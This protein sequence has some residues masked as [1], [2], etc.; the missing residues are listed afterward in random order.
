MA[1]TPFL[2]E[3]AEAASK[4]F[5]KTTDSPK[6][7]VSTEGTEVA[8]DSIVI[9]GY[10]EIGE[11]CL[12]VLYEEYERVE[13]RTAQAGK[14]RRK[15]PQLVAFDS[16]PSL[17]TTILVP[18]Q[19]AVVL[20]GDGSNPAVVLSSGIKKPTAIFITYEDAA[21]VFTATVRLRSSFPTTPIYTRAQ[22]RSEAQSLKD[23]GATE[24]V[25]EADELPRSASAFLWSTTPAQLKPMNDPEG[26]ELFKQAAS[27]A[28]GVPV[29][30]T[31]RL[32]ELFES[33]DQD[34][35]GLVS[36]DELANM[37]SK[38]DAGVH[39]DD[40]IERMSSWIR[41]NVP[42]PM[43]VVG[44]CRLYAKATPPIKQALTDA[45]LQK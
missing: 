7:D 14:D 28:S 18:S 2:G 3:I 38:T 15:L 16:D 4:P 19:D 29:E 17:A 42:Q 20:Y 33:M 40:E 10:G 45:C 5:L 30:I 32:F 23:I 27:T 41:E 13:E 12:R 34:M 11:S 36:V 8:E 31:N 21:R 25:I 44:F 43:D 39:S 9:S 22:T 26:Q 6:E 1:I 24:V 37:I 35:S